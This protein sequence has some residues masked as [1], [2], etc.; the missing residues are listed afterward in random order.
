MIAY[1]KRI[2][3]NK[4]VQLW[5][6]RANQGFLDTRERDSLNLACDYEVSS[7]SKPLLCGFLRS[8]TVLK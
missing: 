5:V 6:L 2:A 7:D 4:K 8:P 1:H 3:V